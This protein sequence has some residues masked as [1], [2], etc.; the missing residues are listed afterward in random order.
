MNQENNNLNNQSLNDDVYNRNQANTY[1]HQ[2]SMVN[3]NNYANNSKEKLGIASFVIGIISIVLSIF[4]SF[5]VL[6]LAI[7]GLV[8]GIINKVKKGKKTDGIILNSIA[9]IV[10]VVV[11]II[12]MFVLKTGFIEFFSRFNSKVDYLTSKNYVAG[13]YDCKGVD[14]NTD[15]YLVTLHLNKDK[16]FIYGPYGDLENNYVKGTYTFEDEHKSNNTGEY[17]YFML[18]MSGS[19]EDFVANGVPSDQDFNFKMEFGLTKKD[20]KKQGVIMFLSSY[21]MYYCYEN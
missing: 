6:P 20:G 9:L 12:S 8:L 11:T 21:N 7:A 15:K 16:T 1:G 2:N 18:T 13:N 4:F 5:L 10:I 14:S 19:K 17:Q 3:N